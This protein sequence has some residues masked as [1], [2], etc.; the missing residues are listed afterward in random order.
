M[1][2][3]FLRP[4]AGAALV[5]AALCVQAQTWPVKPV[6]LVVP[7]GPGSTD[8]LARMLTPK[9]SAALGQQFVVENRPGA[10][11]SV[12]SEQVAKSAADGY[13]LVFGA[14]ASHAVNPALYSNVGYDSLRDFAPVISVAS[15]P[16]V[17]IVSPKFAPRTITELIAAAKSA[18][19]TLTYSSNGA[20]SSQHMSAALFET[21]TGVKLVH[22][23]YK[24]TSE[25]VVAVARADVNMMFANLPPSQALIRDGRVRAV[26][27]T[28]AQRLGSFPDLPTVAESGVAG[29][30][31]STWFAIFAPAATPPEIVGRLNR[32]FGAALADPE[33]RGKLIAQGYTILGGS[34][35]DL[36]ALLRSELVKWAKVVKESGAKVD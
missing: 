11:G 30:E 13:T 26:A 6:R 18:P 5:A 24:G 36:G 12:G 31:V 1:K 15:I 9:V 3:L 7:Y 8:I 22:V 20:G 14:A 21:L 35:Q 2:L 33:I 29:F 32:E 27:V 23:P 17:L 10:A 28:T 19:G 25:G 16:N 4:L 34:P